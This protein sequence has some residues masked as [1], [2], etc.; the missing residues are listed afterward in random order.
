MF[1]L[2]FRI[3]LLLAVVTAG[4]IT[5]A[6]SLGRAIPHAADT[7][8]DLITLC[9]ERPCFLG[10]T[11]G[12]SA[13]EEVRTVLTGI[14]NDHVTDRQAAFSIAPG[15][16]VQL[17]RSVDK[18]ALGRIQ[19]LLGQPLEAGWLFARYGAP[20]GVSIYARD[21]LITLRYPSL[22]ANV[23]LNESGRI[24]SHMTVLSVQFHDPAFKMAM[25]PDLCIDNITDGAR[26]HL[27]RG[28]A[29]LWYYEIQPVIIR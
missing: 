29:P 14:P 4:L 18:V 21:R 2:L 16:E 11:P 10:L 15:E 20:C 3:S 5:T 6:A 12:R 1:W 19:L 9:D 26:N 24:D 23:R 8:A 28:F 13:W 25:Q 22:L 17:F 7:R 27:W